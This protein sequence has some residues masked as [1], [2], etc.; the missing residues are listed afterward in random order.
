[1]AR[2]MMMQELLPPRVGAVE[3]VACGRYVPYD[4]PVWKRDN[5]DE[6]WCADCVDNM[7]C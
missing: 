3:C 1:M 2:T 7:R 6:Y 5:S 4:R